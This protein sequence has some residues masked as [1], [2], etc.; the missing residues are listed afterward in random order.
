MSHPTPLPKKFKGINCVIFDWSGVISD[1]RR[2]VHAADGIVLEKY[3]IKNLPFDAWLADT[4]AS[5]PEYFA[6]RGIKGDVEVLIKEYETAL[7][8][9]RERGVHP[10]LYPDAVATVK[11]L[12]ESGK[13]MFV[14]S[15]HPESHLHR[16]AREYGIAEHF[17]EI[18][19]DLPEKTLAI[20]N[21][22]VSHDFTPSSVVYV[23]DMTYDIQAGRSAGVVC[24]AVSTGYQVRALLAVEK[25]D[26]FL[27]SLSELPHYV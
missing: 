15:K 25:P 17:V 26:I 22:L 21:I 14:V 6:Y 10:V 8:I 27:E 19:G 1:D 24:A 7:G 20:E 23:G 2:P 13:K 18:L 16:E 3:G 11:A 9:V 5:A 12:S 4:K